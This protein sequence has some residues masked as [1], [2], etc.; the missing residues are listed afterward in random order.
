[1]YETVLILSAVIFVVTLVVFL[2]QPS[3]SMFHPTTFYLMFHGL[4][5]VIRPI[6]AWYYGY[7]DRMYRAMHFTPTLWDKVEALICA[8]L[9]LVVFVAVSLLLIREPLVFTQNSFDMNQ[10]SQLMKRFMVVALLFGAIAAY[11]T[12]WV[13]DYSQT[14]EAFSDIDYSTGARAMRATNGYFFAAGMMLASIVAVIAFL[15]RFRPW[16]LAPFVVFALYRFATGQR[17]AVV[18]AAVMMALLYMYDRR[19]KWPTVAV[20]LAAVALIPVFDSIR[21]DRGAGLRESIGYELAEGTMRPVD[22]QEQAEAPLETMDL[23]MMEMVEFL[24]WSIPEK[25]GS[26]DYFLGNLQVFT[27]PIPRALWPEKPIGQPIK[28]FDLYSHAVTIN[29]VMSVPGIGWMYWGYPG[30]VIWAAFFALMYGSGYKAFARGSQSNLAVIGYM[31]FL[32]TAVISYR[33][34]L[35]L[36]VLK[37][38]LFFMTPF[39]FLV[40]ICRMTSLPTAANLRQLWESRAL[41]PETAPRSSSVHRRVAAG[42]E[43]ADASYPDAASNSG[44]RERRRARA[45]QALKRNETSPA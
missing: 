20:V 43:R 2:Q 29:G 16:S 18:T 38:N 32:S 37:Q 19:R 45:L 24:T 44:P 33:D 13:L 40:L 36:T 9:A 26:Y 21:S 25:S 5:F 11:S 30:V 39:V 35:L 1:M 7:G 27:E 10:R 4:V 12:Y 6:F 23:G 3:A 42:Q 34:G 31:I 8:N 15:G 28:L 41:R 17:G 14:G 22:V